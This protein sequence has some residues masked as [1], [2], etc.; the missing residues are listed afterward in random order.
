[1][2]VQVKGKKLICFGVPGWHDS[3]IPGHPMNTD[4]ARTLVLKVF[5]GGRLDKNDVWRRVA[6][7]LD[8]DSAISVVTSAWMYGIQG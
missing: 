7:R 2:R 8:A 4:L 3:T 5:C 1:M 6:N